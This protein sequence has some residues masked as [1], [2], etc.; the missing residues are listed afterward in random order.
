MV[1]LCQPRRG[2]K[3]YKSMCVNVFLKDIGDSRRTRRTNEK[4]HFVMFQNI[5]HSAI[6]MS[7]SE[8]R[9]PNIFLFI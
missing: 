6:V 7:P 4:G 2:C 9:Y 5:I 8:G 1:V 3:A